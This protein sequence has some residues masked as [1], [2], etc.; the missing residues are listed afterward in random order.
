MGD[1]G[2]DKVDSE[3]VVFYAAASEVGMLT[4]H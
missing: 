4:T 2:M 1:P 3:A